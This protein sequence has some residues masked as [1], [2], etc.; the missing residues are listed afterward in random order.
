MHAVRFYNLS[1]KDFITLIEERQSVR[2]YTERKV[3]KDKIDL[4]L[5]AGR[6]APTGC[7]RQGERLIVV[8]SEEGME[9]V[10]KAGKTYGAPVAIVVCMKKDGS[11]TRPLD[12]KNLLDIDASIVTDHMMLEAV[13][14]GLGSCWVCN[15][16]PDVLREELGIEDDLVPVNILLVGYRKG[17]PGKKIRKSIS[18]LVSF[19]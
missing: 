4:I 3:E 19:R 11:W 18:E 10:G 16:N 12:G 1:M 17:E 7:N 14:L 13:D 5:E 2:S 6:L 8:T 15:F 9:K